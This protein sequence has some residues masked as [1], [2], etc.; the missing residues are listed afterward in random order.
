MPKEAH[1]INDFSGGLNSLKDPRDIEDNQFSV[2][3]NLS[4]DKHGLITGHR[5]ASIV[6]TLSGQ[7]Q[8]SCVADDITT[9]S[10]I[11]IF[12]GTG[13]GT[14]ESDFISPVGNVPQHASNN[15]PGAAAADY[16]YNWPDTNTSDTPGIFWPF[17]PDG[18]PPSNVDVEAVLQDNNTSG[19]L[20]GTRS[21]IEIF[22]G[23]FYNHGTFTYVG[24]C[25]DVQM[26]ESGSNPTPLDP[27]FPG[28][29]PTEV[30]ELIDLTKYFPIGSQV[31]ITNTADNN[32]FDD[33]ED[34]EID[35]PAGHYDGMHTVVG[36]RRKM[37]IFSENIFQGDYW[38]SV[39]DDPNAF[40]HSGAVTPPG[41]EQWNRT[42]DNTYIG[43]T[44]RIQ[45]VHPGGILILAADKATANIDIFEFG[46]GWTSNAIQLNHDGVVYNAKVR[47][48]GFDQSVRCCDTNP[49]DATLIRWYGFIMREQ[50]S[51]WG[52][53]FT[54]D[55]H[56][57]DTIN[58]GPGYF[59]ESNDLNPPSNSTTSIFGGVPSTGTGWAVNVV[60]NDI[61]GSVGSIPVG[62]YEFGQTFIYD[63]NQES[64]VT[65]YINEAAAPQIYE[66]TVENKGIKI[67]INATGPYSSRVS[68]GRAYMREFESG[69]EWIMVADINIS[70][71]VRPTLT[72]DY[73]GWFKMP[74]S[75]PSSHYILWIFQDDLATQIDYDLINGYSSD[76]PSI[77]LGLQSERWADSVI[78]NGRV[79]IC[80]VHRYS[81][82]TQMTA[83]HVDRIY[84]SEKNRYDVFPTHNFLELGTGDS[85]FYE[86]IQAYADRIIGFKQNSLDIFNISSS[87]PAEWISEESR[88]HNG[89]RHPEAA[90]E[91]IHGIFWVNNQGFFH[92]NGDEIVELSK[93]RISRSDWV[94]FVNNSTIL[95]YEKILNSVF[96]IENCESNGNVYKYNIT[97]D[98]WSYH[99]NVFSNDGISNSIVNPNDGSLLYATNT[100]PGTINFFTYRN[101]DQAVEDCKFIT[102]D[103][104]FD[105]PTTVKKIY[106][107]YMTYK[108]NRDIA[109]GNYINILK[110]GGGSTAL[111]GSGT[112]SVTTLGID[113]TINEDD[114]WLRGKW[115]YA[116][117]P[118]EVTTCR[119]KIDF[120]DDKTIFH[121]N[122][123]TIEYRVIENK[124]YTA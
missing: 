28:I 18:T 43:A 53:E 123:I 86:G 13:I 52:Q 119:I 112:S 107:V 39:E 84:Y 45:G 77:S 40:Y 73:V 14:F 118:F 108:C 69:T 64:L 81:P 94:D 66:H 95:S 44:G 21:L 56:I 74:G 47:Y 25:A 82:M 58:I 111:I 59:D 37:L 121:C 38:G 89:I 23:G 76:T 17:I 110:D 115:T 26:Q 30:G 31:F 120:D 124:R 104:D 7:G 65:K 55:N 79:F 90:V 19:L 113:E 20:L 116:G 10:G 51:N 85:D 5:S 122:D 72:S 99:L 2:L 62:N 32:T 114:P 16:T 78:S 63:D 103:I 24:L 61:V 8:T 75:S 105:D 42:R 29:F 27:N 48:Y 98:S 100:N 106:A 41:N 1:L 9:Q 46:R 68:G 22:G 34:N 49:E 6:P 71:G 117:D 83:K 57:V 54:H 3:Q 109:D 70:F 92:Y 102:K 60:V 91:T 36:H 67:A 15:V 93:E 33:E 96:I 11:D 50:F 97:N 4:V 35:F 12:P 87:V 80:N 101:V 88:K